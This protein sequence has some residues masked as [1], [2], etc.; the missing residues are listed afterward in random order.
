MRDQIKIDSYAVKCYQAA[1]VAAE[2]V[3]ADG[4]NYAEDIERLNFRRAQVAI[5]RLSKFSDLAGYQR[6]HIAATVVFA[7]NSPFFDPAEMH[8]YSEASQW[9]IGFANGLASSRLAPG[10]VT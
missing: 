10:R 7:L 3:K 6:E 9:M 4:D 5:K 8:P 1:L 2:S